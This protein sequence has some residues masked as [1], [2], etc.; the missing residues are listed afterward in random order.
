MITS[1]D[2]TGLMTM[3]PAFGTDD[4]GDVRATDTVSVERMEH[5]INRMIADGGDIIATTGS[6]GEF[7]TLLFHE[8]K[9]LAESA[10]EIVAN[11]VPLFIGVTS[12]NDREVLEKMK[13][14]ARTKAEGVLVGVPFYFPSSPEN[15]VR[16]YR[17]IAEAFPTLAIMIYHNPPLH[18]VKVTLSMVAELAKLPN[19]VAMKDSH[20]DPV[21]FMRLT[22]MTANK[23]S[24]FVHAVQYAAFAPLG[25]KGFWAI[26]AWMGP[27]PLLALR[28]AVRQG[29]MAKATSIT[30]E[31]AAPAGAVPT[32]VWRETAAKLAIRYAG[33]VDP[34]P[35]RPPFLTVPAEVD[36]AQRK[37]A[38]YWRG[39]SSRYQPVTH[40]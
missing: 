8:F 22:A 40:A 3:M 6:F 2:L 28:E 20:R 1:A 29:D 17:D 21:E 11:R 4:A 23:I 27:W 10:A 12:L 19:V 13:V 34:G 25:A 39:L 16:F 15:A 18:N 26:D 9:L 37:R 35:L 31:I 24:T 38:E 32:T 30:M 36:E 7:H 5:G 14:V 33:Y